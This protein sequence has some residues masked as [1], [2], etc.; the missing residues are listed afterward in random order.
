M[1]SRVLV[2]RWLWMVL[3]AVLI[4]A[5][6]VRLSAAGPAAAPAQQLTTAPVI[7]VLGTVEA[8]DNSAFGYWFVVP[9]GQKFT[10]AGETP[11]VELELAALARQRPLPLIRVW[12]TR[13]FDP[14]ASTVP[15]LVVSQWLPGDET[16]APATPAA[17]LRPSA[18]PL[19]TATAT[20]RPSPPMAT[21]KFSLINL[22]AGPAQTTKV[23]GTQVLGSR[24]PVIGRLA[25]NQWLMLNCG[26]SQTGW[27]DIRLVTVT[28]RLADAPVEQEADNQGGTTLFVP[29]VINPG[30]TQTPVR[31][32][33]VS[34]FDNPTL[35]GAPVA[36]ADVEQVSFNWGAAAP[37]GQ[38]P[39]DFFGAR[40]ERTFQLQPGFYQFLLYADDG[41]RLWLDNELIV[42]QWQGAT[43]RQFLVERALTAGSHTFR[44]DYFE[45]VGSAALQFFWNYSPQL[46][47][48]RVEYFNNPTLSG[49]PVVVRYEADGSRPI[50]HDW[51]A[52][53]PVP[54]VV[55]AT[56]WS[57]R[58]VG[59][60]RFETGNHL[61]TARADDGVRLFINDTPI[62]D[63]WRDGVTDLQRR[64]NGIG[65]DTHTIRVEFYNRTSPA[66]L[67]IWW[68]RESG[69]QLE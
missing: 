12:G 49:E 47:R 58:Y 3:L 4:A 63:S 27:V 35:S 29:S 44:L 46:P 26:G 65:A 24:C 22:Y 61:F 30:P 20:P 50:E 14:K 42:D 69:P 55:A 37:V 67:S 36:T 54:G 1:L 8:D 17:T 38:L 16:D 25:S 64:F 40:F 43:G 2:R 19:P 59:R 45:A 13:Y 68:Y 53:S 11:A 7:G 52:G 34:Y 32:W 9:T 66:R 51:G 48:W 18:T 21:V 31:G 39:A 5:L 10:V 62:V 28:G 15:D 6:P 23:V 56:N 41:V 57:V 60:F 33:R